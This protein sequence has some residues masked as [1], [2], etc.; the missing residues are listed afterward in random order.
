MEVQKIITTLWAIAIPS[1]ILFGLIHFTNWY[2]ENK[3]SR[4]LINRNTVIL[5]NVFSFITFCSWISLVFLT[6][7]EGLLSCLIVSTLMSLLLT[8]VLNIIKSPVKKRKS[9]MVANHYIK[10]IKVNNLQVLDKNSHSY[11]PE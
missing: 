10:R 8:G 6:L 5:T 1:T 2:Q 3:K 9:K 7:S 4:R 11:M